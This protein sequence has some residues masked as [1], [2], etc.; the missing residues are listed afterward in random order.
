MSTEQPTT[1]LAPPEPL[2]EIPVLERPSDENVQPQ[3]LLAGIAS[4]SWL[5]R[6]LRELVF[7]FPLS[8]QTLGNDQ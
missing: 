4:A 8:T 6:R 7:M 2:D 3:R 5:E 1:R